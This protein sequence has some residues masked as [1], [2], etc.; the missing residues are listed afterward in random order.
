M[1]PGELKHVLSLDW[2][3][4]CLLVRTVCWSHLMMHCMSMAVINRIISWNLKLNNKLW[5]VTSTSDD[6]SFRTNLK[7]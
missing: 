4:S 2:V 6:Y 5:T 3:S 1:M 7:C